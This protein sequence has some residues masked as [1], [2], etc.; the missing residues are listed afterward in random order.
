MATLPALNSLCSSVFG[1]RLTYPFV[2][3]LTSNGNNQA[4]L[5]IG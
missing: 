4:G 5:S 3:R 2:P 1:N